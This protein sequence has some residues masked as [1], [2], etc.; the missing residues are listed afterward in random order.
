MIKLQ[1]FQEKVACFLVIS[2]NTIVTRMKLQ[3]V[4]IYATHNVSLILGS[5]INTPI[6]PLCIPLDIC[7]L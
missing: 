3:K 6:T 1:I 7:I 2:R 4:D 5:C